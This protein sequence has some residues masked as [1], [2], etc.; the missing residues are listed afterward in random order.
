MGS[1]PIG[2]QL[3]TRNESR[4]TRGE[5]AGTE[6]RRM[7]RFGSAEG[8]WSELEIELMMNLRKR[9]GGRLSLEMKILWR[10]SRKR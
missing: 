5:A 6:S 10:V 1:N 4:A 7:N 2:K 9:A 8:S 3:K